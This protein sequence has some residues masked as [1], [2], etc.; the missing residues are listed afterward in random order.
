MDPISIVKTLLPIILSQ[1]DDMQ[2]GGRTP[3]C[4]HKGGSSARH[5]GGSS[6]RG[7]G[8]FDP[9]PNHELKQH[10]KGID[11]AADIS[12][13]DPNLIGAQVWAESRGDVKTKTT[14]GGDGNTDTGLMQ[15]SQERWE[16]EIAPNL[17]GEQR[18][19][20][21]EKTGKRPEELD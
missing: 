14:N 6:S 5:S 20:I 7:G 18:Q 10:K 9:G 13:L 15:I 12:G 17:D 21:M 3:S 1:L 19:K 2:D 11:D 16:N 4:G 8:S